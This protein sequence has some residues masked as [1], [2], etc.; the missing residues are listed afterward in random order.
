M[1]YKGDKSDSLLYYMV[2]TKERHYHGVNKVIVVI[3]MMGYKV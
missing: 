1:G 3:V 2:K